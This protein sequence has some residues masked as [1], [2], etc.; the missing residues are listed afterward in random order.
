MFPLPVS[1]S[2]VSRLFCYSFLGTIVVYR[3][4]FLTWIDSFFCC[5]FIF[6]PFWQLRLAPCLIFALSLNRTGFPLLF[7]VGCLFLVYFLLNCLTLFSCDWYFCDFLDC[8][9]LVSDVLLTMK[10]F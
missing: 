4:H 10:I 1:W 7:L 5:L 8:F 6:A 9:F 3:L 2:E